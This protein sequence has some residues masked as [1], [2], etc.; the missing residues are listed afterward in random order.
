MV[1]PQWWFYG[2]L[3][4]WVKRRF[5]VF[6]LSFF[7][8]YVV[9]SA[10]YLRDKSF[11]NDRNHHWYTIGTSL[12]FAYT[13][14]AVRGRDSWPVALTLTHLPWLGHR[15]HWPARCRA[16]ESVVV[17]E[18]WKREMDWTT[19]SIDGDSGLYTSQGA[20]VPEGTCLFGLTLSYNVAANDAINLLSN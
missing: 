10:F 20:R 1:P 8:N 13:T 17:S 7:I 19:D 6:L 9:T 3:V 5:L 18:N 4:H 11:T 16:S 2:F 14:E 15:G 12:T